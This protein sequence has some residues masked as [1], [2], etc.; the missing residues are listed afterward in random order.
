MVM[1]IPTARVRIIALYYVA[2]PRSVVTRIDA[3][4][5]PRHGRESQGHAREAIVIHL[6]GCVLSGVVIGVAERRGIGDHECRISLLPEGP[7]VG[8]THA[9]YAGRC[10]RA[11]GR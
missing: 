11:F 5:V 10:G 2:K 7:V 8:P 3:R 1:A 4:Q 6:V 9:R